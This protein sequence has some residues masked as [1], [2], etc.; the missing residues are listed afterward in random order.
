M[1]TYIH[2]YIYIYACILPLYFKT[3]KTVLIFQKLLTGCSFLSNLYNYQNLII[4][5]LFDVV[6]VH[7][8]F[9]NSLLKK[10]RNILES[11][12][13]ILTPLHTNV[14]FTH[15]R[16]YTQTN[17]RLLLVVAVF[18]FNLPVFLIFSRFFF[19]KYQEV[20]NLSC[21]KRV[22]DV[23][24]HRYIFKRYSTTKFLCLMKKTE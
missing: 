17:R 16:R 13:H 14:K 19:I 21:F 12:P 4:R 3:F 6:C 7:Q 20:F 8:I 1:H 9:T 22:S 15:K 11:S 5:I 10:F 23:Y 24:L 18:F 2:T